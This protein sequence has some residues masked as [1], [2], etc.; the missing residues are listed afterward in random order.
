MTR[1]HFFLLALVPLLLFTAWHYLSPTRQLRSSQNKLL[2]AIA[3][4]DAATC[5][6]LIHPDYTDAWSFTYGSWPAILMDLRAYTPI[7]EISAVD[8]II[9]ASNGVVD[10]AL[11]IQSGPGPAA[12]F[13]AAR[14]VEFKSTT[15]FIWKRQ[16]WTPWSWRLMSIQNPEVEIPSSYTPDRVPEMSAF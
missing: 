12:E 4:K 2:T 6:K 8:P 3:E 9:D 16:S 10:T 1:R 13:I 7:L 5:A 11:L 15:R 14:A